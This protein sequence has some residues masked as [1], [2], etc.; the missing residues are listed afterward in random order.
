VLE[1]PEFAFAF[2][3]FTQPLKRVFTTVVAQVRSKSAPAARVES[4]A[5]DG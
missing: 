3:F 2:T 4:L 5:G 1:K